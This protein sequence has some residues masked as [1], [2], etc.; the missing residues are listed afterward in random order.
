MVTDTTGEQH[1]VFVFDLVL[2]E[3]QEKSLLV[4]SSMKI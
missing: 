1:T 3:L 4:F 2:R